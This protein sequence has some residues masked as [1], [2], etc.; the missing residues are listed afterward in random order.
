M[1]ISLNGHR[2]PLTLLWY[3]MMR[4]ECRVPF[5]FFLVKGQVALKVNWRNWDR[6]YEGRECGRNKTMRRKMDIETPQ[7][8]TPLSRKSWTWRERLQ[9]HQR[10]DR[11]RVSN[12]VFH[13]SLQDQWDMCII[14]TGW[15][16]IEG[17]LTFEVDIPTGSNTKIAESL[18]STSGT[19]Q[20]SGICQALSQSQGIKQ[21]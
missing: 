14:G 8:A 19:H 11:W 1:A 2:S 7:T 4:D 20:K 6:K 9:S 21:K 5:A 12:T 17:R 10:A 3:W 15:W 13:F 16:K 18:A